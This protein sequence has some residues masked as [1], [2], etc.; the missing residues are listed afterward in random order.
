MTRSPLT[1]LSLRQL[2]DEVHVLIGSLPDLH[3]ASDPDELPI[4]FILMRDSLRS[5]RNTQ[6]VDR[7]TGSGR[8]SRYRRSARLAR[9]RTSHRKQPAN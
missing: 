9:T 7:K 2:L 3:D 6:G 1:A 5:E 4:A 8:K